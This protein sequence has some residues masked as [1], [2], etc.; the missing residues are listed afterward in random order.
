MTT[1]P[2]LQNILEGILHTEKENK[3]SM[4]PQARRNHQTNSSVRQE[5][6]KKKILHNQ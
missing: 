4:K 3:P 5:R 1:K 6:R 2:A